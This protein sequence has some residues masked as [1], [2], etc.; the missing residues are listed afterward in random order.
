MDASTALTRADARRLAWGLVIQNLRMKAY[1]LESV[2]DNDVQ[3]IAS[4]LR[5]PA[6]WGLLTGCL[7]DMTA[8]GWQHLHDDDPAAAHSEAVA[9]ALELA[10]C[11]EE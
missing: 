3:A 6:D 11:G 2:S 7:V 9:L 1:G 10:D 5:T 4:A 8:Q